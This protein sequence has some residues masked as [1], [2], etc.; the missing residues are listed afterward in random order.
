MGDK[1]QRRLLSLTVVA[2]F[3]ALQIPLKK[4]VAELV[5]G[6]RGPREDVTE[7]LIQGAARTTAVILASTIVRALADREDSNAPQRRVRRDGSLGEG[8][9]EVTL[10]L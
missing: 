7:A 2:T 8:T 3:I 9:L 6:R 10:D 5:P 1:A 4:L